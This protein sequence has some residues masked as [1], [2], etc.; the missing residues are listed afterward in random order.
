MGIQCKLYFCQLQDVE[1]F[2]F[3]FSRTTSPQHHLGSPYS[4]RTHR[5]PADSLGVIK[6]ILLPEAG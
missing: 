3:E 6:S 2:V 4:M 1:Q 5:Q